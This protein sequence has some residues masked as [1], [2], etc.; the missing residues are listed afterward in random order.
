LPTPEERELWPG[1][2]P[3][4]DQQLDEGLP[5]E[6]GVLQLASYWSI[7]PTTLD[8]HFKEPVMGLLGAAAWA[9]LVS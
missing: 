8:E 9:K 5:G 4:Q 3:G 7:D 1:R 6:E 2:E